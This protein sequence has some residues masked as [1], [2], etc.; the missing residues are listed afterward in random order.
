MAVTVTNVDITDYDTE[1]TVTANAATS[2]VIDEVEVFTVTPTKSGNHVAILFTN[3][4]GH[5]AYTWSVPVGALWASDTATAL[6]GSIAAAA[7]E[8]IQL[9]S[10]KH[11]NSDGKYLITLT[12]A[13]GK[14][15]LTDHVAV[16]EVLETV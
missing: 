3:A 7:T 5:G 10:G 15:L 11:L 1:V 8:V 4:T 14:R 9:A 6:T 13:S 2:S 12:P 16:M